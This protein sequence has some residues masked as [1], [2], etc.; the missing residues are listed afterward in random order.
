MT[1]DPTT[2]DSTWDLAD[3]ISDRI[4][5]TD[6]VTVYLNEV[7][8]YAKSKVQDALDKAAK[9]KNVKEVETLT[10]KLEEVDAELEA[11]AYTIHLTGV[12]SRMREDIA[13]KA[14]SE[15]PF[16]LDLMGRDEPA[17]AQKRLERENALLWHAQ[18]ADVVNAR[19]Q[20]KRDWT[21]GTKLPDGSY[22]DGTIDLFIGNLP[23]SAQV[24]VDTAIKQLAIRV[25]QFSVASK[26]PDF[27]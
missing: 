9:A 24:A 5:P 11:T 15:Y 6:E 3:V 7:A 23:T 20:H 26:T 19:G 14:L 21:V 2:E 13:S 16:R 25:N 1:T 8:A 10:K 4:Q 22:E 12:P 18:I 27:S 17:N